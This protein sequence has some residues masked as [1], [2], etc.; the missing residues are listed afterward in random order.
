M[1][2][3]PAE[4]PAPARTPALASAE[5]PGPTPIMRATVDSRRPGTNMAATFTGSASAPIMLP[6]NRAAMPCVSMLS[7]RRTASARAIWSRLCS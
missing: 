1:P 5:A 6:T 2:A 7:A 3:A 4:A